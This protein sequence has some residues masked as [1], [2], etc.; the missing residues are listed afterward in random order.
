MQCLNTNIQ[1]AMCA[2][3]MGCFKRY[4][5]GLDSMFVA[6]KV[7]IQKEREGVGAKKHTNVP[8]LDSMQ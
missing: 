2:V 6:L 5:K 4:Q 7:I 3:A 8:I 1:S